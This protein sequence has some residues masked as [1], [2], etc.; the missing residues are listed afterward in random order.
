MRDMVVSA[1]N[2]IIDLEE[3]IFCAAIVIYYGLCV[4]TTGMKYGT[5][6]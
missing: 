6:P 2:F 5:D 4:T 3:S 1:P